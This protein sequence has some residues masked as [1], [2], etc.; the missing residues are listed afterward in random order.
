MVD[1]NQYVTFP[2]RFFPPSSFLILFL[3]FLLQLLPR[4]P[5]NSSHPLLSSPTPSSP[6]FSF[7]S[8]PYLS[9]LS[10]FSSFSFGDIPLLP[11]DAT[12]I[13][14]NVSSDILKA[15]SH[16][17]DSNVS[18]ICQQCLSSRGACAMRSSP[19]MKPQGWPRLNTCF[20]WKILRCLYN[21]NV[22]PVDQRH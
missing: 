14:S 2:N 22:T 21:I 18:A 20:V 1:I 19:E 7:P 11:L 9:S 8:F 5:R 3:F 10:Y 13:G 15:T 6:L 16:Q 17:G 12:E 4:L